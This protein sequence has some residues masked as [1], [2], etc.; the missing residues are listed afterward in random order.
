MCRTAYRPMISDSTP[1]SASSTRVPPVTSPEAK[2]AANPKMPIT[3][4]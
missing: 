3:I 2:A 4:S 1:S